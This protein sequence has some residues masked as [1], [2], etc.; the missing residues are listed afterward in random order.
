[1]SVASFEKFKEYKS[2]T[3]LTE[4]KWARTKVFQFDGMGLSDFDWS[5]VPDDAEAVNLSRNKLTKVSVPGRLTKLEALLVDEGVLEEIVFD[6][7]F[8]V[9]RNLSVRNNALKTVILA[10]EIPVLQKIGVSNNPLSSFDL[11]ECV[12][13]L[14]V[15]DMK[16]VID[17]PTFATNSR[18]IVLS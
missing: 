15:V 17:K 11:G 18:A 8:P 10:S 13:E 3:V 5:A 6:G 7:I 14:R 1:M 12:K 9:L 4:S 16:G 2:D